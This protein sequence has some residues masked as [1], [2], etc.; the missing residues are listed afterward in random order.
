M[1]L[2]GVASV[3]RG[4]GG[5][6]GRDA[7][8]RGLQRQESGGGGHGVD[9]GGGLGGG[10]QRELAASGERGTGMAPSMYG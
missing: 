5:N 4:K 7:R 9:D 1:L 2:S 8:H 10:L 6:A 3:L